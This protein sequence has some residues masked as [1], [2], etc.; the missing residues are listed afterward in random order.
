MPSSARAPVAVTLHSPW[1]WL[2]LGWADLRR[3]PVPGLVHGLLIA[4]F[5]ALLLWAARDRF[6]L[7]AGAFSGFLIV[8]PI[9]ATGL[10][11]VSRGCESG[12]CVGLREV[13][14][15]W[16]SGD[17]RLMRFG[18]LLALAGTGWVLTSAGLITLWSPVPIQKPLDFL[19]H[20]VLAP[21]VG[22]F[23]VWLLLGALLAAPVYASTVVA[24][25]MLV[26]T[27]AGVGEAVAQSWRAVA[28]HPGPTVLWAVLIAVLVGVGMLA[29]LLG[30]VVVI[31]L[32]G[33][34]SWH[35]YR[36]LSAASQRA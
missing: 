15:L 1:R 11:A 21:P 22:L 18:L 14:A 17:G 34:A 5:G 10:Y 20:V 26:D 35:A 19:R 28:T 9:L 24:L 6:W 31:P 16:R 29:A 3:N 2:A 30:L 32:I 23:E 27:R 33:H 4:A 36:D 13:L 12:R 8:A 25:P 7:L